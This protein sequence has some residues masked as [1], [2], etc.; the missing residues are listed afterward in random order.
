MKKW[1]LFKIDNVLLLAKTSNTEG[2]AH[3]ES[4][5]SNYSIIKLIINTS[6]CWNINLRK[7]NNCKSFY[8][9]KIKFYVSAISLCLEKMENIWIH[10]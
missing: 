10:Y 7:N 1:Y 8:R 9:I 4:V 6:N 2:Y 5:L 3:D